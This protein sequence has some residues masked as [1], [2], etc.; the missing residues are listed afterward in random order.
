MS[1]TSVASRGSSR[2]NNGTSSSASLRPVASLSDTD[3]IA[4]CAAVI[5]CWGS[6]FLGFTATAVEGF[7]PAAHSSRTARKRP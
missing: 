2:D 5:R 1:S 7:A 4:Q 6:V 3:V